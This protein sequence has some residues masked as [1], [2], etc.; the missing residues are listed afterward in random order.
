MQV[1]VM[2][3]L[4]M[5]VG[6]GLG[7]ILAQK[8]YR[9]FP[10]LL[11][12]ITG[13]ILGVSAHEAG[14]FAFGL[15]SGYRFVSYRLFDWIIYKQKD[16]LKFGKMSIAGT[17]GQC[18]MDP[19]APEPFVLYHLGG[20]IFNSLY[21]MI[22]FLVDDSFFIGMALINTFMVISNLFPMPGND[23]ANV[24]ALLKNPK[25]RQYLY[26]QMKVVSLQSQNVALRDMPD[27]FFY[28]DEDDLET[29][30][31]NTTAVMKENYAM[32]CGKIKQAKE[33]A[34][35]LY[36]HSKTHPI[37]RYLLSCDLIYFN[38]IENQ[39]DANTPYL[40]KDFKR[41]LKQM[42]NDPTCLRTQYLLNMISFEKACH[43][44]EKYPYQK[45]AQR[46]IKIMENYKNGK[47]HCD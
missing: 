17:L 42:K 5:G 33:L 38:L 25:N 36:H 29:T 34:L 11:G 28:Y 9:F 39:P 32:D 41:F 31:G 46:E 20:I 24:W 7:F 27:Y 14:H 13:Y 22:C 18:I 30:F 2:F 3:I 8:S 23:G 35:K 43:L 12:S 4:L 26:H 15:L 16:K 37:Y 6:F 44:L 45:E 19:R 10:L 47:N 1:I 40:T 21:A